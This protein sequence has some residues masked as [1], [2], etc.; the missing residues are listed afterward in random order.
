[1]AAI[2][3]LRPAELV[4][5]YLSLG[6]FFH[7]TADNDGYGDRT[8]L[9]LGGLPEF[10]REFYLPRFHLITAALLFL[11]VHS[12]SIVQRVYDVCKFTFHFLKK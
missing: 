6:P 4:E 10:I 3:P 2:T 8:R 12:A 1:M 7:Q 9:G 5:A 11:F